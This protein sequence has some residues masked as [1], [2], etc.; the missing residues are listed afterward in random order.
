[1]T[2]VLQLASCCTTH[3]RIFDRELRKKPDM[4][5]IGHSLELDT[6]EC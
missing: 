5:T 1:M 3:L 6:V 2:L 4:L